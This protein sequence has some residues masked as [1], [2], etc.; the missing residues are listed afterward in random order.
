MI[1]AP[2]QTLLV[3]IDR[4]DISEKVFAA[5]VELAKALTA[6]LMFIHVL[7][8]Q[9]PESP[10]PLYDYSSHEAARIEPASRELYEQQ[11]MAYIHQ[12]EAMLKRWADRASELGLE[13]DFIHPTGKVGPT[14][15]EVARTSGASVLVVGS[16]QRSGISELLMG[17]TSNYLMHHAPCAVLVVHPTAGLAT[18][19]VAGSPLPRRILAALDLENPSVFETALSLAQSSEAELFL[20]HVLSDHGPESPIPPTVTTW[21]YPTVMGGSAWELYQKQWQ[22]YAEKGRTGLQRDRDRAEAAGV[23]VDYAQTT[24]APGRSICQMAS[25]WKTDLI[26]VGSHRR[27]GLKELMLGSVSNYVMHHAPCSVLVVD[28]EQAELTAEGIAVSA[29]A[30]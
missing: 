6:K 23:T 3:A 26:V 1:S 27:K 2:F 11:W 21:E 24:D 20:L 19:Q 10:Q 7:S 25:T 22:A 8:P 29:H 15:C 13:A 14:L 28:L 9:D 18:A 4:D 5:A 12:Y 16:H 30:V 17:S